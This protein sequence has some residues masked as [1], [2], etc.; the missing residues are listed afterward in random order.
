MRL[1]NFS[2][3][4]FAAL[5]QLERIGTNQGEPDTPNEPK[6]VHP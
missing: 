5:S 4:P 1:E 3:F 6:G 2:P